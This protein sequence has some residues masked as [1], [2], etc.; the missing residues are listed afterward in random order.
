MDAITFVFKV[1]RSDI[2]VARITL[3]S[4]SKHLLYIYLLYMTS[5]LKNMGETT[6][7]FNGQVMDDTKWN[8][9][10]DGDHLDMS[11][12]KNNKKMHMTLSNDDINQL[13]RVPPSEDTIDERL[14]KYLYNNTN[15]KPIMICNH[16]N[17]K[18]VKV[19]TVK[20]KS[21]KTSK[22]ASKKTSKRASKKTSK[23]ASKKT[24]KRASKKNFHSKEITPDYLKTIY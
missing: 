11:V 23:R 12:R 10:Y 4:L 20:K 3:F 5:Y 17:D 6:T 15:V 18:S 7:I 22:H 16:K 1:F 8:V 21:K 9:E 13:L 2:D 14:R 19:K 24:S